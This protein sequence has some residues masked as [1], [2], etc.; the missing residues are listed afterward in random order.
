MYQIKESCSGCHYCEMACP[1]QAVYY[2]G[3][4]YKINRDWCVECGLCETLCPTCSIFDEDDNSEPVAHEKI[5]R[6]CDLVVCGGGSGLVAAVK[7][8][9]LGKKVILL[10]KAKRV[11]GNMCLAHSFFPVYSKLHAE[12]GLN[13]VREDAVAELSARTGGVIGSDIMRTAVY[14]CSEFT[15]WLLE[16]PGA[17]NCFSLELYGGKYVMARP[18]FGPAVLRFPKRIEN[19]LS[20]DLSIGPGFM[21]SFVKK[22]MLEAIPAQKLNVEILLGHEAKHLITDG[23]GRVTGVIAGDPGGETEIRCKAVI[24]STGGYGASDTKLQ[25]YFGAFDV[26]R[27]IQRFTVPSNTGDAIDMLQELGVEPDSER[28]YIST[29]GPS[30]HPFSYSLCRVLEHSTALLVD[31]DGK[32]WIDESICLTSE[33]ARLKGSLKEA[34][35]GIY[36]QKNI[37]DIMQGYLDDSSLA[38]DYECLAYYQENLDREAG[39]RKPPVYKADTIEELAEKLAIDPAVLKKTT[40]DYNRFCRNGIDEEFNKSAGYLVPREQGPYYAIYGQLFSECAAGGLTVDAK[41]RVL[42]NDNT[43][44]SGL[45]AGGDAV[46]AMHRRGEPAV[47]SELTWALA[48]AYRCAVES[49]KEMECSV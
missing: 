10:E 29:S 42:H 7:A 44:V 14:G 24:L 49:V 28:M 43:P 35:W 2:D 9:Q 23:A 46:S 25:K 19:K 48:S 8:S 27:P 17:R 37:D 36:T 20:K 6:E 45:Y 33:A 39:Y 41:C 31:L 12:L 15:D 3:S 13:D 47:V 34:T 11:G 30:H 22:S 5:I 1:M 26:Q 32:R 4:K 16:F 18:V 21:G 40:E 38:D